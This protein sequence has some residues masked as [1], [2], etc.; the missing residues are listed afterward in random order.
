M[1]PIFPHPPEEATL[2]RRPT[3]RAV[4]QLT[5][6]MILLG[7]VLQAAAQQPPAPPPASAQPAPPAT[8]PTTTPATTR[9]TQ[10]STKPATVPTT[11]PT[12]APAPPPP[13]PRQVATAFAAAIERG[14]A[15]AAKALVVGDEPHARWVDSTIGLASALKKLDTAAVG[16]FG[17]PGR[18]VS[19]GALGMIN[20]F[21]AMKDAQEK[22][23]GD[24]AAVMTADPGAAPLHMRRIDGGKWIIDLRLSNPE[25]ARQRKL[26]DT[27]TRAA[28]RTATE[29]AAGKYPT[30]E[31]A[32]TALDLRVLRARI[33]AM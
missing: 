11:A 10:A 28:D 3:P 18:G 15:P 14:D 12:T 25:I 8:K 33:E 2:Y 1:T 17:E 23:E 22:V 21:A 4:R 6:A 32:R 13:A 19:R 24:R 26:L 30:L 16:K 29:L 9:L 31:A 27:L 5:G 20:A 7:L